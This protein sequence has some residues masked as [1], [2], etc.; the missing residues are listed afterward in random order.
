MMYLFASKSRHQRLRICKSCVLNTPPCTCSR[1]SGSS[2]GQPQ[3]TYLCLQ[4]EQQHRQSC[5]KSTQRTT[6]LPSASTTGR[7]VK[8]PAKVT[9]ARGRSAFLPLYHVEM[10]VVS[11]AGHGRGDHLAQGKNTRHRSTLVMR[12]VTRVVTRVHAPCH[13]LVQGER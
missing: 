11:A 1:R 10:P 8:P 13:V 3:H 6:A 4:H 7:G 2:E 12:V 5:L 9:M